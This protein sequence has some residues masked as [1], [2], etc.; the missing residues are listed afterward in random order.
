MK[1]KPFILAGPRHAA[2]A[3]L[4]PFERHLIGGSSENCAP[5]VFIVGP[6]RSGT[7]LM[8]EML[9]TRFRFAYFSNAAHRVYRT[10]SAGT[11]LARHA[12]IS[13]RGDYRSE[14]GKIDGWGAPCEGGWIWQRW[15]SEG[16]SKSR[17][18][19]PRLPIQ[20]MRQTVGAIAGMLDAP[21]LSKNVM[22]STQMVELDRIFPHCVFI[23]IQRNPEDC[24]R[25]IL[26]LRRRTHG[27]SGL[28][29]WVSVKPSGWMRFRNAA[30]TRQA[31]AQVFGV[32]DDI[33]HDAERIGIGRRHVVK[34]ERLCERPEIELL[35]IARFLVSNGISVEDRFDLPASCNPPAPTRLS[36]SAEREIKHAVRSFRESARLTDQLQPTNGRI[37]A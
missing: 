14:Y 18:D 1:L 37:A 5:A 3:V 23:E 20:L 12:I 21:F 36:D 4:A 8:Y 16:I 31:A 35:A 13:W 30:P 7:T 17:A 24:I 22:H 29:K 15:W 9:V 6:P 26:K 11:W 28:Q 2:M 25:S 33:Q 34:Y 10:P 27:E 19:A 32:H